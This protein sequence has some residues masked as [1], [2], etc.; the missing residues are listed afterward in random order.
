MRV[1]CRAELRWN[2]QQMGSLLAS[3][4]AFYRMS[5]MRGVYEIEAEVLGEIHNQEGATKA[6]NRIFVV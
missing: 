2:V 5:M 1:C 3:V 6:K 4:T